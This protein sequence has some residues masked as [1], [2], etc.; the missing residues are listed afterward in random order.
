MKYT[1]ITSGNTQAIRYIQCLV[2]QRQLPA[3]QLWYGPEHSG[4]TTVAHNLCFWMLCEQFDVAALIPCLRCH[5]CTL[6][7][8]DH[9][10]NIFVYGADDLSTIHKSSIAQ[11]IQQWHNKPLLNSPRIVIIMAAETLT[12]EA[13]NALLKVLEEPHPQI[14]FILCTSQ[15][16]RVL[17]TIISRCAQVYFAGNLNEQIFDQKI[18]GQWL[19]VLQERSFSKRLQLVEEV[20]PKL[21]DRRLIQQHLIVLAQ[22]SR[23][24][25]LA[26][27]AVVTT[28]QTHPDEYVLAQRFSTEQSL[29]S[30]RAIAD[31][32]RA[33]SRQAQ[34][35][36]IIEQIL[37]STYYSL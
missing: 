13:A 29:A 26:Q 11:G 17:P 6:L 2:Q 23:M 15:I 19:R 33:L 9:H 37:L 24:V 31:A 8:R 21:T 28:Q 16:E 12:E 1:P 18:Y 14:Y 34:P 32:Y 30:L 27:Q 20:F 10:P 36:L 4:K 7:L 5:Q 25:L 3:T 35:K 22:I